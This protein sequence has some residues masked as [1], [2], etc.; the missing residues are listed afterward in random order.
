MNLGFLLDTHTL[1]WALSAPKRLPARVASLVRNPEVDV[2]FSAASTWEIAIK[3]GLGKLRADL[4]EIVDA[5]GAADFDELAVS[6]SH[7]KRVLQLPLHHRDPFDRLLIA[8][9]IEERLTIISH[10][11]LIGAYPVPLLW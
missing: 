8:Q 2:Y 9:A 10:D 11:A 1:L 4:D 3:A 6:V 5:A 7:T